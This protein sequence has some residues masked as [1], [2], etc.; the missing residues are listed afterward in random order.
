MKILYITTVSGTMGFFVEIIKDLVING[1]NVV[2]MACNC[3]YSFPSNEEFKELR[4]KVYDLSCSRDLSISSVH[5]TIKEIKNIIEA[6][7]YDIVHCHTPIASMCTRFACQTFRKKGLKVFY[8]AHGFHFFKGA[9]LKNWL[10]YCPVEWICAHWTDVLITINKEDFI[11]AKK[12]MHAKRI[13]YVPG[14]GIDIK[15]FLPDLFT[16]D[17]I[18]AMRSELGLKTNEKMVLSVDDLVLRKNHEA[19][20]KAIAKINDSS[21]KYYICGTG[22]LRGYLEKLIR[23]FGLSENVKLLGYRKDISKL[24]ACA[25]LFVF[26]SLQEGMPV[27]MM[28]AIASK[29]PVICSN[30][31]SNIDLVKET[32]LFHPSD[33][34]EIADKITEFLFMDKSEEVSLN[35]INLKK[36]DLTNAMKEIRICYP[37]RIDCSKIQKHNPKVEADICNPKISTNKV[38]LNLQYI[39]KKGD[40]IENK[41]QSEGIIYLY[42]LQQLRR[43]IE[44]PIDCKLLFSAGDLNTNKNHEV[45]IRA[46]S[47]LEDETV[48]Y[49]IAGVGVLHNYLMDLVE[50]CGLKD[51]VHLLGFRTDMVK[52]YNCADL[53]VHPS[54]R[55]GLSVTIMEAMTARIPII[56]SD[57]RGNRDLID[58]VYLFNP[59]SVDDVK[60]HI[61]KVLSA[62]KTAL[63]KNISKNYEKVKRLDLKLINDEVKNLYKSN[64]T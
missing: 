41:G 10:L 59:A 23:E 19:V 60:M 26:P 4:C 57:I 21:V 62:S 55:E 63:D 12:H 37:K 24:C 13:E 18:T 36:F 33:T 52:L 25:D 43:S 44:V 16:D 22:K 2:D 49:A 32:A 51:R 50:K 39:S 6:N 29:T 61:E 54:F 8:T 47:Q 15:K 56:C 7:N 20:I 42:K 11:F 28:E 31:C 9:A 1:N 5:R 34:S 14:V 48:H 35:Y 30:I 58:S 3:K 46:L 53:L 38:D 40:E 45:V 17:D 64:L 27:A